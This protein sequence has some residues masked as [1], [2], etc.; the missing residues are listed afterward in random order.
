MRH[1]KRTSTDIITNRKEI[2]NNYCV[3]HTY[4]RIKD[5]KTKQRYYSSERWKKWLKTLY[6]C[7]A[8]STENYFCGKIKLHSC[9]N[10][11]FTTVGNA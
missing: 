3:S 11:L 5:R 8:L 1:L 2:K 6:A 7:T 4:I 9:F 10:T